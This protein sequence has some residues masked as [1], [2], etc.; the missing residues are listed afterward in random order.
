MVGS[1]RSRTRVCLHKGLRL[2]YRLEFE[3]H[4]EA[5]RDFDCGPTFS[6]IKVSALK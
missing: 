1:A 5:A 3:R 2:G 6:G 4:K